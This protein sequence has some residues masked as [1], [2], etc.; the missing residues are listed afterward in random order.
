MTAYRF[1]NTGEL[2]CR[3]NSPV[4]GVQ[5]DMVTSFE[6]GSRINR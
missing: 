2:R 1:V 3:F 6:A 5:M 4:K